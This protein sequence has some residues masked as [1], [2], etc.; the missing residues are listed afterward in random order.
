M[1][2]G[3]RKGYEDARETAGATT[4]P[5]LGGIG[6]AGAEEG[7]AGSRTKTKRNSGFSRS[8]DCPERNSDSAPRV[9]LFR[10]DVASSP[11]SLPRS[12]M[13]PGPF[14]SPPSPSHPRRAPRYL[15]VLR[16]TRGSVRRPG[17]FWAAW[18]GLT[19]VPVPC[20]AASQ[21]HEAL[22]EQA[23]PRGD[24]SQGRREGRSQK[25]PGAQ[26][27]LSFRPLHLCLQPNAH[28]TDCFTR[29]PA[30]SGHVCVNLRA[31]LSSPQD[32]LLDPS[33][34]SV[35]ERRASI[36]HFNKQ[37]QTP[38]MVAASYGNLGMVKLVTARLAAWN[39]NLS[40]ASSEHVYVC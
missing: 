6:V 27:L 16:S 11:S 20:L 37:G 22:R 7:F 33:T 4:R 31:I 23:V 15:Q 34:G 2:D 30:G 29:P 5:T 38:L 17:H 32:L 13:G 19:D 9:A 14:P 35:S 3:T 8:T 26:L 21:R 1:S 39:E 10:P 40:F 36:E 12:R 28:C 18:L 25:A 24:G